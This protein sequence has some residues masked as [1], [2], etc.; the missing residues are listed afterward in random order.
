MP[1]KPFLPAKIPKS[2]FWP[3]K[4]GLLSLLQN[5]HQR[6]DLSFKSQELHLNNTN[7][8]YTC[9][10]SAR[11]FMFAVQL[12]SVLG[13]RKGCPELQ[14]L[15]FTGRGFPVLGQGSDQSLDLGHS[16]VEM[17]GDS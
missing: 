3:L 17:W 9:T 1:F 2:A 14:D 5:D 6:A 8:L 15:A 10:E 11:N 12:L 7:P 16:I 13:R 4:P